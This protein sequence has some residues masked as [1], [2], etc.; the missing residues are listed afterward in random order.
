[1]KGEI[2]SRVIKLA[3]SY[4]FELIRSKKHLVF[5]HKSG[6]RL[7]TGKSISDNRALKNIESSIKKL[8]SNHDKTNDQ[9]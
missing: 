1:M 6:V 7:V 9:C 3:N 4:G 5:K 8:L 2:N